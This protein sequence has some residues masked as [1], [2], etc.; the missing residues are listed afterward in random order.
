[1][2]NDTFNA[3]DLNQDEQAD[4][5]KAESKDN[6]ASVQL[7]GRPHFV[8]SVVLNGS[9]ANTVVRCIVFFNEEW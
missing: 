8:C 6:H 7:S 3:P 5:C 9:V 1:M 2:V 4:D